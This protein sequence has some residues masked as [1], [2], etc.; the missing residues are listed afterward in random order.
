M[1]GVSYNVIVCRLRRFQES[2]IYTT[3]FEG[4][5][6]QDHTVWA[7]LPHSLFTI[8]NHQPGRVCLMQAHLKQCW[9]VATSLGFTK[10]GS[11]SFDCPAWYVTLSSERRMSWQWSNSR[12]SIFYTGRGNKLLE[13]PQDMYNIGNK[14][15][16][17]RTSRASCIN[18]DTNPQF[19]V[20][21]MTNGDPKTPPPSDWML[22][23][24]MAPCNGC[25]CVPPGG[26]LQSKHQKSFECNTVS[27]NHKL[28]P[29]ALKS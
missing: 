15:H 22:K 13:S 1:S 12:V 5:L 25:L 11:E 29:D 21:N 3:L 26:Y 18:W 20:R 10:Y 2:K 14:L 6:L 9:Q 19:S 4:C 8:D 24:H 28:L 17:G 16:L 27:S 23:Q 7:R